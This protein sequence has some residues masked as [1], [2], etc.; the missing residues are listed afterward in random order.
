MANLRFNLNNY[1]FLASGGRNFLGDIQPLILLEIS[2]GIP[3]YNILAIL[4]LA[5]I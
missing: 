2:S 5:M 1:N 4:N 3:K